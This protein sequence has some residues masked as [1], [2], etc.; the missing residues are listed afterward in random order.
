MG[1][2]TNIESAGE[3][4]DAHSAKGN[5]E[6]LK[7]ETRYYFMLVASNGEGTIEGEE[8]EVTTTKGW[9]L[10]K[11]PEL[12]GNV[13]NTLQGLSCLGE[14][15]CYAVG[16]KINSETS[17]PEPLAERWEGTGTTWFEEK[18]ANPGGK[19]GGL[20][21]GVSC[22]STSECVAAGDYTKESTGV[23]MA[24]VEKWK[25]KEWKQETLPLPT[26][27]EAS[28]LSAVTCKKLEV[29]IAVGQYKKSSGV[30]APLVEG[31]TGTEWKLE[32]PPNPSGGEGALLGIACPETESKC[33]AV[34]T[35]KVLG[36]GQIAFGENLIG[37][38]WS[39]K[40]V[41]MPPKARGDSLDAIECVSASACSA[42][43]NFTHI[44]TEIPTTLLATWN[45]TTWSSA[46]GENP[47]ETSAVLTGIA[48]VSSTECRMS[49]SS[50]SYP[51]RGVERGFAENL[52]EG[53][54]WILESVQ[55]ELGKY[56][57]KMGL[58][59]L[60]CENLAATFECTSVGRRVSQSTGKTVA[61]VERF[62]EHR[63]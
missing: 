46:E 44:E 23:E 7:P 40:S 53:R 41:P 63:P 6:G 54:Q 16:E 15:F 49:G 52:Y 11:T 62:D 13:A 56:G 28:R 60:S 8:N 33:F 34:G 1:S 19:K 38:S 9:A 48:C 29:C 51:S 59:A 61:L 14:S 55:G 4:I 26:G 36:T 20:L 43:G 57:E 10:Q 24:L 58:N 5:A 30:E 37:A 2:E 45:G 47:K 31:W 18:T 39:E 42:V 50:D 32:E 27:A 3:G 17:L 12:A 25:A 22:S 21:R 35:F